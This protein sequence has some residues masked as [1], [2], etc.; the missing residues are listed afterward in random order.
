MCTT[1]IK[2]TKIKPGPKCF[3]VVLNESL[4][5]YLL[6][7]KRNFQVTWE[8]TVESAVN[9]VYAVRALTWAGAGEGVGR[10]G[11]SDSELRDLSSSSVRDKPHDP[12]TLASLSRQIT[13]LSVLTAFP[14]HFLERAS[15]LEIIIRPYLFQEAESG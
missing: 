15:G 2:N 1:N 5:M 9:V 4:Q 10:G 7:L 13:F 12:R 8:Y 3:M 14:K 11:M 6:A